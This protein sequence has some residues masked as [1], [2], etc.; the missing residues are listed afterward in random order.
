MYGAD[1]LVLAY[2]CRALAEVSLRKCNLDDSV[3]RSLRNRGITI[4]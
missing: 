3:G 1:V 2:A 4:T